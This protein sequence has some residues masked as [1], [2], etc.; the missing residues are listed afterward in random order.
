MPQT[1]L[2]PARGSSRRDR[3]AGNSVTTLP[4]A[5]VR[6]SVRC[7]RD[8]WPPRPVSRTSERRAAPVSAPVAQADVADVERRVAVEHEDP[9]D[10]V[11]GA[12]PI[13]VEGAAGHDLLGGL[14]EEP[15]PAAARRPRAWVSA[16]AEAGADQAGGVHVVAA[17]VGD[18]GVVLA[19]GSAGGVVDRQRVE[20]GTQRHDRPA[21]A[22]VGDQ[23]GALDPRDARPAAASRSAT[24]AVVRCLRP[25]ELGVGVE[26]AAE[27][28][29]LVGVLLDDGLDDRGGVGQAWPDEVRHRA[30]GR[31]FPTVSRHRPLVGRRRSVLI[32]TGSPGH[33]T[34]C[35]L[36][37]PCG[38]PHA[39]VRDLR[40]RHVRLPQDRVVLALRDRGPV[41]TR[42]STCM[43]PMLATA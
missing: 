31:V 32:S 36:A 34:T 40:R 41:P 27:L 28:D 43:S 3:I 29:Q 14:E 18:A 37:S 33:R 16:S 9:V 5:K 42:S 38:R 15:D 2:T 12:A 24:T 10:L 11:E 19:H 39:S 1:T 4:S 23:A 25:R 30:P 7:G 21:V 17:G 8:V 35:P 13:S 6:S 26:V 22:E 20:V